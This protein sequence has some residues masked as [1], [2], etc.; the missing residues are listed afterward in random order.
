MCTAAQAYFER[1]HLYRVNRFIILVAAFSRA[2]TRRASPSPKVTRRSFGC[3]DQR[4]TLLN[5]VLEIALARAFSESNHR[6]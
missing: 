3:K 2:T 5:R 1:V 6:R 4:S